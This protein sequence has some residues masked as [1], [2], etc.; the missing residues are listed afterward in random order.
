[1]SMNPLL[2]T[3]W[4]VQKHWRLGGAQVLCV[5]L[6]CSACVFVSYMWLTCFWSETQD[7]NP[8]MDA[9][10]LAPR[11][12]PTLSLMSARA[13]SIHR[14]IWYTCRT[15]P[16][17][18]RSPQNCICRKT[19]T[20]ALETSRDWDACKTKATA[21]LWWAIARRWMSSGWQ[22]ADHSCNTLT[23]SRSEYSIRKDRQRCLN[24]NS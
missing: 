11:G 1:M 13:G 15:F 3:R 2:K 24:L 14:Q 23:R 18:P 5:R 16:R 21:A 12:F 8:V 10:S 7:R 6:S 20:R 17:S 4:P 19:L 9:I 22:A